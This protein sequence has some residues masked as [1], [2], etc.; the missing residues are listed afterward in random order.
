MTAQ[1]LDIIVNESSKHDDAFKPEQQSDD[2][3]S[4]LEFQPPALR[5]IKLLWNI[6]SVPQA[7]AL[8]SSINIGDG[9]SYSIP[10]PQD[11]ELD[12]RSTV[13][14]Y[15]YHISP[16]ISRPWFNLRSRVK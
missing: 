3:Y 4:N 1:E 14:L 6:H 9:D 8:F 13:G 5:V 16:T 2:G 7:V 15:N 12:N 10:L 11:I